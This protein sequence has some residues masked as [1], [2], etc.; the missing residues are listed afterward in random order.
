MTLMDFIRRF[1]EAFAASHVY[2]SARPSLTSRVPSSRKRF[3]SCFVSIKSFLP[4]FHHCLHSSEAEQGK[5]VGMCYSQT[6]E[7]WEISPKEATRME[8]NRDGSAEKQLRDTCCC[9]GVFRSCAWHN[10]T[11][12]SK[13]F[14]FKKTKSA[15]IVQMAKPT[16]V[17]C[18]A[19]NL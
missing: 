6:R 8:R 10:R 14:Y 3:S 2:L 5:F 13:K 19:W 16:I 17:D 4:T 15:K 7:A 18:V 1:F 11:P 12:S 9:F